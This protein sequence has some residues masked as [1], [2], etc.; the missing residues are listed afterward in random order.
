MPSTGRFTGALLLISLLTACKSD[1]PQ[2]TV[3]PGL[4]ATRVA[5]TVA[6]QAAT[7]TALELERLEALPGDTPSV[8]TEAAAPTN[9]STTEPSLLPSESPT[10]SFRDDFNAALA[11]GWTWIGEN[12]GLWSLSA[13]P[14]YLRIT[15][16]SGNCSTEVKNVPLQPAPAGNYEIGTLIDFTPIS[17][18]QVAGL[19]I[20]Q[21][22]ANMLMFGRA[23]CSL[24]GQCVGNGVYFDSYINGAFTGSNFATSTINPSRLHIRLQRFANV[25][26]GFYS[27][28]GEEWVMIGQHSNDLVPSG[29][30]LF[31]GQSCE[32]GVPADFDF[33]TITTLP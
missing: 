20:Y 18:F 4:L 2:N 9:S 5:S 15:L 23:F 31:T 32:E 11:D 27:E 14:G 16:N 24:V 6:A 1:A 10:V 19:F 8:P 22:D 7:S 13:N 12:T 26:K 28:D 25:F 29:V 17:D 33:F 30:G 21:D 3:Q